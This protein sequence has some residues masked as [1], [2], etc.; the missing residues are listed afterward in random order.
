[1]PRLT[2]SQPN[3]P[4][5]GFIA[6]AFRPPNYRHWQMISY[7]SDLIGSN[8]TL[9]VVVSNPKAEKSKHRMGDGS[10]ITTLQAVEVLEIFRDAE[11]RDNVIIMESDSPSPVASVYGMITDP[12]VVADSDVLIGCYKDEKDLGKWA[13]LPQMIAEKNPGVTLIDPAKYAYR[14][15]YENYAHAVSQLQRRS[16]GEILVDEGSVLPPFLSDRD[17]KR[18]LKLIYGEEGAFKDVDTE[19][20]KTKY[21]N[22]EESQEPVNESEDDDLKHCSWC[23]GEF[24]ETELRKESDLGLLCNSCIR[25]IESRGLSLNFEE[26]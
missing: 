11:H 14:R 21:D 15:S 3:R 13:R 16:N 1:M 18:C 7:F 10:E 25:A 19:G 6:G 8:G 20:N 17:K 9:V 2:P 5:V 22:D 23:G 26:D 4:I 12:D 24:E